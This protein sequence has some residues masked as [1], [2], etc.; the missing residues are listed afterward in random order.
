[1]TSRRRLMMGNSSPAKTKGVVDGII[2]DSLEQVVINCQYDKA[3]KFYSIGDHVAVPLEGIGT[4]YF[5]YLGS[6]LETRED[7]E[8]K[9]VSTW[10]AREFVSVDSWNSGNTH[11]PWKGSKLQAYCQTTVFNSLPEIIRKNLIKVVKLTNG[12]TDVETVWLPSKEEL[13]G[14]LYKERFPDNESRR[15]SK[16]VL[17]SSSSGIYSTVS[18][19]WTRSYYGS[20]YTYT[21]DPYGKIDKRQYSV[22]CGVVPGFCI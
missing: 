14:G 18:I 15:K 5:D 3:K 1:M 16:T 19:W 10:L 11:M 13:S 2:Q 8:N 17:V 7:G 21:V 6:G 20:P 22:D 12:E 9:P 4:F